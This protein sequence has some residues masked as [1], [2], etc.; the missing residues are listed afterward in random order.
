ME[1]PV[2]DMG[3]AKEN[4]D[5]TT[6]KGLVK[7]GASLDMQSPS[8]GQIRFSEPQVKIEIAL[9][10]CLHGTA[11]QDKILAEKSQHQ[12]NSGRKSEEV[13]IRFKQAGVKVRSEDAVPT[14]SQK[15]NLAHRRRLG[16]AKQWSMDETQS[17]FRQEIRFF[18]EYG[19]FV[20]IL[21]GLRV[22]QA[23]VTERWL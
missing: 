11:S 10:C 8:A 1:C 23:A 21:Q 5:Q 3:Q 9:P 18:I 13:Q 4:G 14:F 7:K 22:A 19:R 20:V 17:W 2:R 6:R 12:P 15:V 16:M